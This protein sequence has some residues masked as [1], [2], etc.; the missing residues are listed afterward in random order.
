MKKVDL[1]WFMARATPEP[2]SGCWIWMGAT[3]KS[4]S[5]EHGKLTLMQKNILAH[6]LSYETFVGPIPPGL[7]VRHKCDIGVCVNP[8]HLEIG[9]QADNLRDMYERKRN[10]NPKGESVGAAKLTERQVLEISSILRM[11]TYETLAELGARYGV[12]DSI[13]ASIRDGKKW[14]HLNLPTSDLSPNQRRSEG[15]KKRWARQRARQSCT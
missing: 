1:D 14:K 7:V 10:N 6:R 5:G 8:E 9:T 2:N 13:I 4:T 3:R 12:G 15:A 11:G